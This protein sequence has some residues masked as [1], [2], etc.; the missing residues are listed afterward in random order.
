MVSFSLTGRYRII[1]P[2]NTT[3]SVYNFD[4]FSYIDYNTPIFDYFLNVSGEIYLYS[5]NFHN[6]YSYI[7][8]IISY[9]SAYFSYVNL[10]NISTSLGFIQGLNNNEKQGITYIFTNVIA[11]SINIQIPLYGNLLTC[12]ICSINVTACVFR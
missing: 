3:L 1:V 12:D 2:I 10:Y 5:C 6:I 4:F 9:N 7:N 11:E 8:L